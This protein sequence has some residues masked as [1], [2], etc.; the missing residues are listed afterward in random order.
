EHVAMVLPPSAEEI[1]AHVCVIFIGSSPP[2]AEWLHKKAK[3]SAVRANKVRHAL[4]WL[5]AHNPLYSKINIDHQ[6]LD[7]L[8]DHSILPFHIEHVL[9]TQNGDALTSR[10]DAS[11]DDQ[12]PIPSDADIA[13]QKLVISDVDSHASSNEL[14]AAALRHIEKN[15]GGYIKIPHDPTPENEFVNPKLFPK[16]YPTL[17]PYGLGGFEDQYQKE[18][19][20]LKHQV[21]HML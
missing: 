1:M 20:S 2:S 15:K 8:P 17:F 7:S 18:A 4:I 14:R 5:K 3:P 19:I 21:K 10:Y 11:A 12:Q 16:L 13:F 9:P 6:A